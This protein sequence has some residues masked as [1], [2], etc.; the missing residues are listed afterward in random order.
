MTIK[1]AQWFLMSLPMLDQ[2]EHGWQ[3]YRERSGEEARGREEEEEEPQE[4]GRPNQPAQP[5]QDDGSTSDM[6]TVEDGVEPAREPAGLSTE[7]D[8]GRE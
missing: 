5:S 1:R 6:I 4:E 2:V 3:C 8:H 7:T